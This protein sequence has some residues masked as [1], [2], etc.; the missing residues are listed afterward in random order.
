VAID[1]TVRENARANIR[2]IVKRT[3]WKYGQPPDK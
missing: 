3:Q 2:V 1:W